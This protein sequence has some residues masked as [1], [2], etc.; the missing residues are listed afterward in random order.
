M[1]RPGIRFRAR[2]D[3][4][5]YNGAAPAIAQRAARTE[6]QDAAGCP[7]R[8][9]PLDASG[10]ASD[11]ELYWGRYRSGADRAA[12]SILWQCPPPLYR[13]QPDHRPA[14]GG[15]PALLPGLPDSP[16]V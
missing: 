15:G 7:V 11:R 10:G 1:E 12:Q 13:A 3:P 2:L 8:G 16:V 6:D 14:A 4:R 5:I 9:F